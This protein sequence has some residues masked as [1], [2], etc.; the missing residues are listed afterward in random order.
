MIK[1]VHIKNFKSLRDVRVEFAP[2]TVLIGRGG[3]GKSNFVKAIAFLRDYLIHKDIAIQEWGTAS[4]IFCETAREA[5]KESNEMSFEVVFDIPGSDATFDYRV[6]FSSHPNAPEFFVLSHESLLK[7]GDPVFSRDND[8]WTKEPA[9]TPTPEPHLL[10]LESINGLPEVAVAYLVLTTGIGC[11]DFGGDVLTQL[12]S[13]QADNGGL[14]DDASNYLRTFET[15]T[16]NLQDLSAQQEIVVALRKL[17]PALHAIQ[18]QMPEK[19]RVVVSLRV[20]ERSM[21]LDLSQE[22]EGLRRFFAHLIAI[23]Q[24][25]SKQLL[26]FEEPEKGLYSGA[27]SVLAEHFK[28]CPAA[29]R[30]QIVL[31]THSPNLLDCFDAEEIRVVEMDENFETHIGKVSTPQLEALREQL[32]TTGE[33]LSVDPARMESST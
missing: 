14:E 28:A 26:M 12:N 18:I 9:V 30:G 3:T 17:K 10:A 1:R 13:R 19:D 2:V 27:L 5:G 24:V 29:G 4:K 7:D 6:I 25:S 33:L 20:G 32:M 31:T 21:L 23:Y 15:I 8:K 16:R 22:S 11:Y